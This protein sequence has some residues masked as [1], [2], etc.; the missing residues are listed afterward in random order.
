MDSLSTLI[1]SLFIWISSHLYVVKADF[2]E[3]NYQEIIDF[4]KKGN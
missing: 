3:P 1:A 2:K 4:L